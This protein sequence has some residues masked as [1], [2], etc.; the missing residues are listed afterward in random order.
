MRYVS[1]LRRQTLLHLDRKGKRASDQLME[2]NRVTASIGF[3]SAASCG[4]EDCAGRSDPALTE[5]D[6]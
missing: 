2:A 6:P 3:E 5:N 1:S 4:E